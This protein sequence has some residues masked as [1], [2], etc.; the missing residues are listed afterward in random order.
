MPVGSPIEI[1]TT[2][3]AWHLFTSFWALLSQT[4]LV[5]I[6]FGWMVFVNMIESRKNASKMDVGV[7]AFRRSE[8]EVYTAA[9]V[10]FIFAVPTVNININAVHYTN[11]SCEVS[12]GGQLDRG[13][14]KISFGATRTTYDEAVGAPIIASLEGGR[15][16]MPVVWYLVTR[17]MRAIPEALKHALPCN[18]DLRLMATEISNSQ[19]TAPALRDELGM[20]QRDCWRPSV[21]R[22]LRDKPPTQNTGIEDINADISWA[23]SQFFLT[24][25]GYYDI[26]RASELLTSFRY[27]PV[28]DESRVSSEHAQGR[29]MPYCQ[30]WWDSSSEGLRARLLE[31]TGLDSN[32]NVRYWL[33]RAFGS[34]NSREARD[35][36][37]YEILNT[38]VKL[39]SN[40]IHNAYPRDGSGGALNSVQDTLRSGATTLGLAGR[41]LARPVHNDLHHQTGRADLSGD[42]HH[43]CGDYAPGH[44]HGFWF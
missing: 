9:F 11:S 39:Q 16:K 4:G 34:S 28:R 32:V 26:Y 10:A 19:V 21:S 14:A 5:L 29:G 41:C 30:E 22:F 37:L 40:K 3:L 42:Y 12:A 38:D 25:P 13:S 43:V 27:D 17:Y 7:R 20:F 18:P 44:A 23:G 24:T 2:V 1:Y 35:A 36:L 6:P 15:P 8:A 33:N 31:D